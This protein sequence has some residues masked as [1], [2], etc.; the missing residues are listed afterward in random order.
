VITSLSSYFYTTQ[1][2]GLI[3]QAVVQKFTK[4]KPK[5]EKH[6]SR[7]EQSTYYD[8][9]G[10]EVF[11][12][13]KAKLTKEQ[14]KGFYLGNAIKYSTRMNWKTPDEPIRDAQKAANYSQWLKELLEEEG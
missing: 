13:I 14:L 5:E 2:H 4:Q 9:G 1:T 11:D 7:D 12:I 8:E 10:I 6:M 3:A